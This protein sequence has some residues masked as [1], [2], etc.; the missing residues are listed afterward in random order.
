MAN[1]QNEEV[2]RR[3]FEVFNTG[4]MSVVDE[5]VADGAVSHDP[6]QPEELSG[7]EGQ[8]QLTQMYRTAYPDLQVTVEEQFSDGDLVCTR[9]KAEGTN[10]GELAGMPPT[11]KS[12]SITGI[13]IDKVQDGKVV[14]AWNHWDNAGMMQQLGIGAEA[15]AAAGGGRFSQ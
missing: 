7:P 9:W 6:A 1:Q 14:E 3:T 8:K 4:D 15:G 12:I 10:D 11:G 13:S 5:T 2:A